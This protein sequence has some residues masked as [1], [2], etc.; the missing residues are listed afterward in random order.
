M[1]WYWILT[2]LGATSPFTYT[3]VSGSPSVITSP[4]VTAT[5]ARPAA[6]APLGEIGAVERLDRRQLN[7]GS[8]ICGYYEGDPDRPRGAADGFECRINT[9][10]GLW[11]FCETGDGEV[12]DMVGYCVDGGTCSDGCGRTGTSGALTKTW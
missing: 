12:C 5:A 9:E 7:D 4:A 2:V 10:L 1:A 11:N 8:G 3:L 6:T